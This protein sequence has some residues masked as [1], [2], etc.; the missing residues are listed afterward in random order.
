VRRLSVV[1]VL[2]VV[3]AVAL[4]WAVVVGLPSLVKP[5]PAPVAMFPS[6]PGQ[7]RPAIVPGGARGPEF[8]QFLK[9]EP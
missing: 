8:E 4:G 7:R 1:I 5:K 2:G 3:A 9:P 6:L